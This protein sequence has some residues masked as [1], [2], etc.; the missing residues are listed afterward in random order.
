M[1]ATEAGNVALS[2]NQHPRGQSDHFPTDP[3]ERFFMLAT[4]CFDLSRKLKYISL[5]LSQYYKDADPRF[6]A[7]IVRDEQ[8]I[9]PK[10]DPIPWSDMAVEAERVMKELHAEVTTEGY[11]HYLNQLAIEGNKLPPK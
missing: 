2:S 3:D 7:R 9:N 5:A 1:K 10:P 8:R 4:F 6:A 11:F